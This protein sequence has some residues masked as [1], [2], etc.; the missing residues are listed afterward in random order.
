MARPLLDRRPLRPLGLRA[1]CAHA[2]AQPSRCWLVEA[3]AAAD[4]RWDHRVQG[5]RREPRT[6]RRGTARASS[7]RR[8][9]AVL[10]RVLTPPLPGGRARR[11]RGTATTSPPSWPRSLRA[12]CGRCRRRSSTSLIRTAPPVPGGRTWSGGCWRRRAGMATAP[13]RGS[14]ATTAA[15]P[16]RVEHDE[17]SRW[18]LAI[19]GRVLHAGAPAALHAAVCRAQPARRRARARAA[20]LPGGTPQRPGWRLLEAGPAPDLALAGERGVAALEQALG[21]RDPAVRHPLAGLAGAAHAGA[22]RAA[23]RRTASSTSGARCRR[24]ISVETRRQRRRAQRR[25]RARRLEHR[26]RRGQ[27]PLPAPH[28]RAPAARAR[29]RGPG[30][31]RSGRPGAAASTISSGSGPSFRR[32]ARAQPL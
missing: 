5:Q 20:L 3:L 17:S 31:R 29:G 4:I 32:R 2:G 21:E 26:A 6:H 19:D 11:G 13:A 8:V 22:R 27:R 15:D 14:P 12:G 7:G 24:S 10:N 28:G 18:V 16:Q 9:G 30:T 23:A 25:A 1:G